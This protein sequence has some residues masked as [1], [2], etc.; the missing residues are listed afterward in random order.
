MPAQG[1]SDAE[2]AAVLTYLRQSWGRRA[3]ALS[4][5]NVLTGR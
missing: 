4:E 2:M 1:L 3:S 5:V